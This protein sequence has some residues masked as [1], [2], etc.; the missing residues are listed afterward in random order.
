MVKR[1]IGC[2][3][4]VAVIVIVIFTALGTGAYKSILPEEWFSSSSPVEIT[5][6]VEAV[7]LDSVEEWDDVEAQDSLVEAENVAEDIAVAEK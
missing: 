7:Q 6:H 1:I 4:A 3:I 5:T 2:V